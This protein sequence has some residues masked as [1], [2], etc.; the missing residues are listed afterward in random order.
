ML[1]GNIGKNEAAPPPDNVILLGGGG[2]V[3]SWLRLITEGGWGKSA[4]NLLRNMW[5]TLHLENLNYKQ[6]RQEIT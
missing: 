4:N 2:G 1:L 3:E 6:I 5:T